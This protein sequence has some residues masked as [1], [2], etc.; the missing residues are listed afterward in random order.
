V[1][2]I[3]A[4]AGVLLLPIVGVVNDFSDQHGTLLLTQGLF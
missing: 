1:L 4:P 3:P 2:E